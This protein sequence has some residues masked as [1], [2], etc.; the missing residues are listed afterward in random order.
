[1][2]ANGVDNPAVA[3]ATYQ[4]DRAQDQQELFG[5][6]FNTPV[7]GSTLQ[8]EVA[9]HHNLV[10]IL[11]PSVGIARAVRITLP[12]GAGT[13]P[14]PG[15]GV[16]P[17]A[18]GEN[19]S[20]ESRI[21]YTQAVLGVTHLFTPAS[22]LGADNL[23]LIAEI[24]LGHVSNAPDQPLLRKDAN[25]DAYDADPTGWG[26]KILLSPSYTN[27]FGLFTVKP[28]IFFGRD[29]GGALP[30][31]VGTYVEGR[32]LL[33]IGVSVDYLAVWQFALQYTNISAAKNPSMIFGAD[34]DFVNASISH[35]F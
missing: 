5:F 19:V 11:D 21:D 10:A 33:G 4:F 32:R 34:R 26:I 2:L 7:G 16:P 28:R 20:L 18:V 25:G 35:S 6:S 14:I 17:A 8:G 3:N 30:Q 13:V 1:M 9:Y 15:T 27:V 29:F 22:L 23:A 12:G 24:G 31:S